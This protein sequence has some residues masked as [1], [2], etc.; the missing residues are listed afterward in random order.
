MATVRGC[1]AW[2]LAALALSGA[3]GVAVAQEGPPAGPAPRLVVFEEFTR[4]T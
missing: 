4:F 1:G 3:A 2:L